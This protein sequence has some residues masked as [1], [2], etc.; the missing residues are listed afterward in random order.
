MPLF[1]NIYKVKKNQVNKSKTAREVACAS[2]GKTQKEAQYASAD[3]LFLLK[4]ATQSN[5][6]LKFT[7]YASIA[8]CIIFKAILL[9]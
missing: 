2:F 7:L 1:Q 9:S 5:C 3:I 4:A 8:S 6:Y